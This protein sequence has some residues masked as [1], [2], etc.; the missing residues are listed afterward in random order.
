VKEL[1]VD[2]VRGIVFRAHDSCS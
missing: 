2:C 1:Q